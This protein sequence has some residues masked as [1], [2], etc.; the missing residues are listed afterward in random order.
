MALVKY[1]CSSSFVRNRVD[2]SV[3]ASVAGSIHGA[4]SYISAHTNIPVRVPHVVRHCKADGHG[5]GSPD[6]I[7]TRAD[8]VP[9]SSIWDDM[10]DSKREVVL[11]M[12]V[13]IVLEHRCDKLGALF[14]REGDDTVK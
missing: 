7:M 6:M 4:A 2:W 9:S 13:D 10:G 8:G 3:L 5:V 11:W 14:Q 1:K 12:V